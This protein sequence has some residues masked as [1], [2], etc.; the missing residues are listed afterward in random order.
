MRNVIEMQETEIT[1]D[2]EQ[3]VD[4]WDNFG[5]FKNLKE[6]KKDR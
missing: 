6:E 2:G 1:E 4:I 3:T 5:E